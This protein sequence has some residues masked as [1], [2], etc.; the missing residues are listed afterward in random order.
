MG[1]TE[2]IISSTNSPMT[3]IDVQLNLRNIRNYTQSVNIPASYSY[4]EGIYF[5]Y[6]GARKYRVVSLRAQVLNGF[7][8]GTV[9]SK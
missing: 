9:S 7:G 4:S 6:N 3:K 5:S 1:G 8:Y 2:Y